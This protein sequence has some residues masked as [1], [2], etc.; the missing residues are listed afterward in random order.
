MDTDVAK[1]GLRNRALNTGSQNSRRTEN[2]TQL[3]CVR[4]RPWAG[5]LS[6]YGSAKRTIP[7]LS[8]RRWQRSSKER[9]TPSSKNPLSYLFREDYEAYRNRPL[10]GGWGTQPGV[11]ASRI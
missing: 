9:L 2:A 3:S 1:A 10:R 8:A 11:R 4:L 6:R 7:R 5:Q